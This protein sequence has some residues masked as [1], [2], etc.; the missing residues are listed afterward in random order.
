M[1]EGSLLESGK[2][3]RRLPMEEQGML[4]QIVTR[5]GLEL[6]GF[7]ERAGQ[8]NLKAGEVEHLVQG[9][10]REIGREV[11]GVLL[12]AADRHLCAHKPLHDRRTRTMVTLFG[13][14]DVTRGRLAT[15][16]Y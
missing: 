14:T 10:V 6:K 13:R 3:A 8:G 11:T 7:L 4:E 9:V 5:A 12:E 2:R 16:S 1:K 15:G